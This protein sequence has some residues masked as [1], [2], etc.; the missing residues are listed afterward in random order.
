[1][2]LFTMERITFQIVIRTLSW[3]ESLIL[4]FVKAKLFQIRLLKP[5]KRWVLDHDLPRKPDSKDLWTQS[6]FGMWF[7]RAHFGNAC[8]K[9]MHGSI[10]AVGSKYYLAA[11]R[12]CSWSGWRLQCLR[13][14]VVEIMNPIGKRV[15]IRNGFRNIIR[16][17]VIAANMSV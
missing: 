17:F 3:F 1:M 11:H 7:A 6:S 16:S 8:W 13:T 5:P 4:P 15:T 14:H 2:G 9:A 10:C 12:S